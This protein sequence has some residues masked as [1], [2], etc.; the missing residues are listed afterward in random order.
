[1]SALLQLIRNEDADSS[2]AFRERVYR[3][4]DQAEL[5][6]DVIA[7][8][9]AAVVGR[10]FL[11][12]G[13]DD[14]PGRARRFPGISERSWKSFCSAL[15]DYLARTV[16]PLIQ[17]TLQAV[18]LDGQLVGAISLDACEDPPYLLTRNVP[19]GLAAGSGWARRGT[20]QRPLLRKHLQRIFAARFKRQDIGDVSVGFPGELP[21]E[22]LELPVMLLDELPSAVAASKIN[23]MLEG[24]RVSKDVLGRSDS[25]IARLVHTQV[26]G[27]SM[28]YEEQG[29]KTMRVLLRTCRSSTRRRTIITSTNCAPT[30]SIF[31]S[32]I[33]ATKC[34]PTWC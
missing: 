20:K 23:R 12:I 13:V 32:T 7:L 26:A 2:I 22:E 34:R 24:R 18:K 8:A 21:R 5:L 10:R 17:I 1:M 28:P 4:D 33:S 31:C 16:E 11:F 29:T 9:N 3:R 25:H 19:A 27:S 15:P 30:G 6:R 14:K